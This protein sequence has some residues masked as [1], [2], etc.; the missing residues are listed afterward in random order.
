MISSSLDKL[1]DYKIVPVVWFL[2]EVH[3][4]NVFI[5]DCMFDEVNQYDK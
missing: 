4:L 3:L 2:Y 1:C 5:I